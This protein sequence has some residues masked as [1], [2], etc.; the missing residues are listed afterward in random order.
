MFISAVKLCIQKSGE[1][2]SLLRPA[3]SG[4]GATVSATSG[5]IYQ[6]G[7]CCLVILRVGWLCFFRVKSLFL[8]YLM[9]PA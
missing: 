3:S 2:D 7:G 1:T 8:V 9:G 4:H 5:F 6:P